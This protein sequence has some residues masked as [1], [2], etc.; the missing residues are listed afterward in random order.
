MT[1][2]TRKSRGAIVHV[3]GRAV[4]V[5]RAAVRRGETFADVARRI[6]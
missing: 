3:A 6:L 5:P 1:R 4:Y 2:R